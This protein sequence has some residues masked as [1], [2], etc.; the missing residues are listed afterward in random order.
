MCHLITLDVFLTTTPF[1]GPSGSKSLCLSFIRQ[2]SLRVVFISLHSS[3]SIHPVVLIPREPC[4]F[5]GGD[6]SPAPS[7]P[8]LRHFIWLMVALSIQMTK[9]YCN[10]S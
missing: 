9:E 4:N 7:R 5:F 1:L 3:C 10:E 8:P 2:R 6:S